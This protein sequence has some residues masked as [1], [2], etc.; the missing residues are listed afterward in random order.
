M[1]DKNITEEQ[2]EEEVEDP[3]DEQEQE[4]EKPK[5]RISSKV[6]GL[7]KLCRDLKSKGKTNDEIIQEVANKYIEAGKLEKEAKGRAKSWVKHMVWER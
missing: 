6:K 3:K 5:R 7:A 4:E 1:D 2:M